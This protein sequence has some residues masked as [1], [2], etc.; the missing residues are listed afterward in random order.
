MYLA[1]NQT[2]KKG[3][4]HIF[5]F[6]L[7]NP[8]LAQPHG[9]VLISASSDAGSGARIL[10]QA[11]QFPRNGTILGVAD[12]AKPLKVVV[13][14]F[15]G[16]QMVQSN[17]IIGL[18]NI[19]TVSLRSNV[20][21]AHSDQSAI[22]ISGFKNV[23]SPRL[24]TLLLTGS[25][26]DG[27]V[28]FG[29]TGILEDE[30]L[31]LT[32]MP[33]QTMIAESTYIFAFEVRNPAQPQLAPA[34]SIEAT[35]TALFELQQI[36]GTHMSLLGVLNGSDPLLAIIPQFLVRD[37]SQSQPFSSY[38]NSYT[39]LLTTNINLAFSERKYLHHTYPGR[40][41]IT[42][43]GLTDSIGSNSIAIGT[44]SEGNGADNLF[45]DSGDSSSTAKYANGTVTLYLH[46]N[47]TMEAHV[48]YILSFQ[49]IN[50]DYEQST[51]SKVL[52]SA[53]GSANISIVPMVTPSRVL[54]GISNGTDPLVMVR[55]LFKIYDIGQSTPLAT[56]INTI[57]VSLVASLHLGASD[58]ALIRITG[59]SNAIT[60]S[61]SV[62]L[63][64]GNGTSLF[65]DEAG[66][67][68]R[69]L[70]VNQTFFLRL[71]A[72]QIM[73]K[74]QLYVFSFNVTNPRLNQAQGEVQVSASC[75]QGSNAS[76]PAQRMRV[77]NIT[78]LGVVDG[79]NPLLVVIPSFKRSVIAQSDPLVERH[80]IITLTLISNVNLYA[81]DNSVIVI[82]NLQNMISPHAVVLLPTRDNSD[83]LLFA[84]AGSS[85]EG[86]ALFQLNSLTLTVAAGKAIIAEELYEL[87]FN[88]TNPGTQQPAPQIIIYASGTALFESEPLTTPHLPILGVI[89]GSDVM[90][91][92]QPEFDMKSIAQSMPLAFY[93]NI[94]TVTLQSNVNLAHKDAS[95]IVITGLQYAI[96]P[97]SI[98]LDTTPDGY[99]GND[100]FCNGTSFAR[101]ATFINGTITLYLHEN[102]TL[103]SHVPYV[104]TFMLTNPDSRLDPSLVSH[105]GRVDSA[106]GFV[107]PAIMKI[108]ARGT[109]AIHEV[110]MQY[111]N[112]PLL[113]IPNGANPLVLIYEPRWNFA[114]IAQSNPLAE[115][116]NDLTIRFST[117]I[118]LR[119]SDLAIITG[120]YQSKR[121][122]L[123]AA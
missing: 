21:L 113:G 30:I 83:H 27:S 50:P 101:T 107:P 74:D 88:V 90:L 81:K 84:N 40:S 14:S 26:E 67:S 98:D 38:T 7:F 105:V 89:N 54:Y 29:S 73:L 63:F 2:M 47:Q 25:T 70:H 118:D 76:I 103:L 15:K 20:N 9:D 72:D 8:R 68:G 119:G 102:K 60:P 57:T 94:F 123:F 53:A 41:I 75:T 109:A 106:S 35:G 11:M 96:G 110:L 19:I 44:T 112:Q 3:L 100:L 16:S 117:N 39:C 78:I 28:V 120:T 114:N 77:Q 13:P 64:G 121:H 69:L 32:V 45:S 95:E 31:H 43:F 97:S 49:L 71:A 87:K 91:I 122:A 17:P 33:G 61:S 86:S 111:P 104:I 108:S 85:V 55:T 1:Q 24:V 36:P 66:A 59:I 52:I 18:S 51:A 48:P 56:L 22:R 10:A 92:E 4:E 58:G 93:L 37:I 62:Q 5:S 115:E 6:T 79:S 65:S 116:P 99:A 12:G 82:S 23:I 46:V 80:N 34:I 42:I